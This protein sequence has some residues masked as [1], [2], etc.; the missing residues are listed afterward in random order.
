MEK[1]IIEG[2]TPLKGTVSVNGAK[3]AAVA[4]LPA[5]VLINGKCRIENLPNIS[6]IK[7]CCDILKSLGA[8]VD[9]ISDNEV[10]IDCSEI[11]K[12][13]VPFE[14]TRKF[15]ASYYFIGS[16]LGR[17]RH[18]NVG[19]PGG[20]NLG[21]RPIDQHIKGFEL[22]GANVECEGGTIVADAE[23]LAGNNVYFDIVSVGATINVM[24]AAVL[25]EG[26]T[27]IENAAK[28]PHVV[29]IA[30]FLNTMGANIRGAGTDIIKITGVP[31][32]KGG[33]TY[34]IV[35]DQI[36]AGT[37]MIAAAA[38][39]GNVTITN[40]IT[41]HLDSIS[42]KLEEMGVSVV[43]NDDGDSITVSCDNRT[44]K[45]SI[46]TMPHPGFPTDMQPQ[47]G[48]L[49]SISEGTSYI[50]EGIFD[51]RFQYTDEL[52][53]L[54][55]NIKVNGKTAVFE[56]VPSLTGC[57]VTACDLR[58]GAALIIAGIIAQGTTEVYGIEYVDR[59]YEHIEEKFNKLGA[60][61]KR[62]S[63]D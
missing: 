60:K 18:A 48:V 44:S 27:I 38:S 49:L 11:S 33:S 15:R 10:E 56:G 59:G 28:E 35:P 39:K 46:K 12:T 17:F 53:K 31:E 50:T 4:I 24:L 41:K 29:D 57:P 55:A 22:L 54:G 58:A 20:C 51:S 13:E 19:S 1:L 30:N 9:Y 40:C 43:E 2:G 3:N 63:I 52:N 8:K 32:L 14:I 25:A 61:I 37:Y 5:T 47:T 16:L 45:T 42:A 23:N 26:T 21:S 36:E 34:S 7:L 62:V 6:D